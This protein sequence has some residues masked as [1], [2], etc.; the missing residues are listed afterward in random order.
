VIGTAPFSGT[1]KKQGGF[2]R[3][4]V[5]KKG[6]GAKKSET[7][8][9]MRA[10]MWLVPLIIVLVFLVLMAVGAAIYQT[11]EGVSYGDALYV[12]V[13]SATTIGAPPPTATSARWFQVFYSLFTVVY[14]LASFF[15]VFGTVEGCFF[16]E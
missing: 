13:A 15:V 12:A 7:L 9:K 4:G 2:Y 6:A 3:F 11:L 5:E 1:D 14:F 10:K 16:S 8:R